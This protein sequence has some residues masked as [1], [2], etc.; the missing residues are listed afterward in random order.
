MSVDEQDERLRSLSVDIGSARTPPTHFYLMI[1]G[2]KGAMPGDLR[3]RGGQTRGQRRGKVRRSRGQMPAGLA[4]AAS[5]PFATSHTGHSPWFTVAVAPAAP[6]T[7]PWSWPSTC[8]TPGRR[9]GGGSPD[10]PARW[11]SWCPWTCPHRCRW[12]RVPRRSTGVPGWMSMDMSTWTLP[13][14]EGARPATH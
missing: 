6:A 12:W 7:S 4:P 8:P 2:A 9:S 14:G 5:A 1:M 10:R 3:K 13:A 11:R